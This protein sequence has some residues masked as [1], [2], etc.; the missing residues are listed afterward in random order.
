M[1]VLTVIV[2]A[3]LAIGIGLLV[4]VHLD[5]VRI[6]KRVERMKQRDEDKQQ[7]KRGES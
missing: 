4:A 6:M 5:D 1:I 2:I 3:I 7:A